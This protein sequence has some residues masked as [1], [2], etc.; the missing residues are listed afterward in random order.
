MIGREFN[1]RPLIFVS[2]IFC[3]VVPG[4]IKI[5]VLFV[6]LHFRGN[7]RILIYEFFPYIIKNL[8]RGNVVKRI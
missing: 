5:C 2:D 8:Y 7:C 3:V 6:D 4:K 1:I